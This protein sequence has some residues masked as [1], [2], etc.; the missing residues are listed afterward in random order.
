[1]TAAATE[2][3]L[4]PRQRASRKASAKKASTKKTKKAAAAPVDMKGI[5]KNKATGRFE[6]TIFW[7]AYKTPEEAAAARAYALQCKAAYK[8]GLR[9]TTDFGKR[10]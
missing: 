6:I 10:A 3:A 4:A 1:M 9:A 7:G 8:G 2:T 5:F